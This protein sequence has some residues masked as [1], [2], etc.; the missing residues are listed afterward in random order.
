[1]Q[2]TLD[3]NL[4]NTFNLTILFSD[5]VISQDNDLEFKK[6]LVRK[7]SG[8]LRLRKLLPYLIGDSVLSIAFIIAF[9]ILNNQKGMGDVTVILIYVYCGLM[10]LLSFPFAISMFNFNKSI[11]KKPAIEEV[12]NDYNKCLENILTSNNIDVDG[13]YLDCVVSAGQYG[14]CNLDKVYFFSDSNDFYF[15][16]F[17]KVYKLP[18]DSFISVKKDINKTIPLAEIPAYSELTKH[19]SDKNYVKSVKKCLALKGCFEV[20]F[21]VEGREI[22]AYIPLYEESFIISNFGYISQD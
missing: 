9:C 6:N 13:T 7:T 12:V 2:T 3:N 16:D 15:T 5:Y 17:K 11:F 20:N 10:V 22:T 21:Q 8:S 18:R 14:I 1:M 19:I 4:F